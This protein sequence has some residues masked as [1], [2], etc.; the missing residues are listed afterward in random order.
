MHHSSLRLATMKP[1][2]HHLFKRPWQCL[3]LLLL[4]LP[5]A[6]AAGVSINNM[7]IT[8]LKQLAFAQEKA[9]VMVGA[10]FTQAATVRLS[11]GSVTYRSSNTTVAT[12]NAQTGQVTGVLA[13]EATI[14]ADQAAAPPY[15][16]ASAS[17]AL[18]VKGQALVFNEWKL[19]KVANGVAPFQIT[20]PTSNAPAG[21]AISYSLENRDSGVIGVTS[22]GLAH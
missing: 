22:Q 12:V 1:F 7:V 3:L 10:Q 2:A 21:A 15:A 19:N 14:V 13:G 9:E 6:W 4:G 17:Y 11:P 8:T 5:V 18:K 16:A 20:A